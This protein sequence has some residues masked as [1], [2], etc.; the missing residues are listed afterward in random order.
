MLRCRDQPSRLGRHQVA[1][2][3]CADPP[4]SCGRRGAKVFR[5]LRGY[6]DHGIFQLRLDLATTHHTNVAEV[7]ATV[8]FQRLDLLTIVWTDRRMPVQ[9]DLPAIRHGIR[10]FNIHD[11][12]PFASACATM[13]RN[14]GTRDPGSTSL[15]DDREPSRRIPRPVRLRRYPRRR[16]A[17]QTSR[18]NSD[19]GR[20]FRSRR[21]NRCTRWRRR[22]PVRKGATGHR[23]E[24]GK[25]HPQRQHRG[26]AAQFSA[27]LNQRSVAQT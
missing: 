9:P 20:P 19:T 4:G 7:P 21:R 23:H 25:R 27:A 10:D 14:A 3:P 6:G 17:L 11:A 18:G 16:P 12:C 2:L 15:E 8:G 24:S 22:T 13:P 26:F 5:V 1:W